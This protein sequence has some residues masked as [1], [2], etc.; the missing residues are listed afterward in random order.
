ML[1][2]LTF[3]P[4]FQERIWGGR[5]LESLY[6]K[7]L[8]PKVSIGESWE[9]ADRS[10]ANSIITNGNHAGKSLRWLMENHSEELMGNSKT[11][12]GR[13]PLLVKILDAREKLSLQVHPPAHLAHAL[14]GEPKTEMWYFTQTDTEAQIF[15]GLRPGVTESIFTTKTRKGSVAE[16]FHRIF[17]S[18]GDAMFLPS[19]RVHALGQG[20]VVF[21]IQQNSD[22]TYR[23]FDWDRVDAHGAKRQLHIEQSLQCI[24]FDDFEPGLIAKT[25]PVLRGNVRVQT[26]LNDELFQVDLVESES[27]AEFNYPKD[28]P[29]II[30]V[31][32]GQ[33]AIKSDSD[34]L[35]LTAGNFAMIPANLA[36][37][38]IV[39]DPQTRLLI[40]SP[41]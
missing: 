28:A 5:N 6:G 14:N 13:F 36:Q 40:T 21:E 31:I 26:L 8:P 7:K 27:V 16:C 24:N 11:L 12:N 37:V 20:M 15:A 10:D 19:G 1:Y 30:G 38:V 22:S 41:R 32:C 35:L 33:I 18:P 29:V 23:V 4:I 2:P 39:S 25:E 17:V 3:Q 9:I 34:Q